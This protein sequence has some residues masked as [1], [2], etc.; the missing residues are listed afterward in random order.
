MLGAGREFWVLCC[1]FSL[2]FWIWVCDFVVFLQVAGAQGMRSGMTPTQ[3][4][5]GVLCSG[6]PDPVHSRILRRFLR[7]PAFS[8]LLCEGT[9]SEGDER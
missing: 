1:S 4:T 5:G 7:I 9:P 8:Y 6:I 3:P 2:D